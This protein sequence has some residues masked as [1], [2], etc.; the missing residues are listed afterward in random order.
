MD[1]GVSSQQLAIIESATTPPPPKRR[2]EPD[3]E[4]VGG[5]ANPAPGHHRGT[6]GHFAQPCTICTTRAHPPRDS[7]NRP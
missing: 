5:P 3:I 6:I 2:V 7:Q 4:E 1:F